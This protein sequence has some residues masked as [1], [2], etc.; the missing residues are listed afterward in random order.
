M[1]S[2]IEEDLQEI[3]VVPGGVEAFVFESELFGVIA[4]QKS[5]C[6]SM[7]QA[8]VGCRASLAEARL[9]FLKRHFQLP[10]QLV[11]D[12][13]VTANRFGEAAGGQLFTED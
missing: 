2:R 6:G 7:N 13:P 8:E 1:K 11:F 12:A 9:V 5:Q 10:M 4:F 3:L